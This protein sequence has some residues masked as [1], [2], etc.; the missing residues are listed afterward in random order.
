MLRML[1]VVL[2]L[3]N[4]LYFAWAQ[5][6]LDTWTQALGL[7]SPQSVQPVAQDQSA[8]YAPLQP[9]V[10][11]W[12]D[13]AAPMVGAEPP[14]QAPAPVP[15][16]V[17]VAAPPPAAALPQPEEAEDLPDAPAAAEPEPEAQAVVAAPT[18]VEPE[19]PAVAALPPAPKQCMAIGVFSSE[20][21]EPIRAA[22]QGIARN[23]WRIKDSPVSGRWMV[24]W[25]GATDELVLSA[26]RG[27]LQSKGV[28]HERLRSSP[29]G[30]GFSLGRFSSE[31][32][33][34][35]HKKDVERKGIRAA[36]VEVERAPS[37]VYTIEFPDYGA[38]KEVVRRDLGRYIG[39]RTWQ[40]C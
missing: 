28:P 33:A 1:V 18:P 3:A 19:A 16:P 6:H 26:R 36:T 4:G 17:V 11:E 35:Q 5:G 39:A 25:G 12:V 29:V 32:A 14:A 15:A 13:A 22:L 8:Q 37:T 21:M 9:D 30:I 24:F 27:E 40:A 10:I 7:G 38:V 31:A 20:Q 23:Q 2:L 34:H